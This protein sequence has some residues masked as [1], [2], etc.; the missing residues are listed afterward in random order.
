MF[1]LGMPFQPSV[2]FAG[3]AGANPS[4]APFSAPP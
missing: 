3:K 2:M 1:V 4:E